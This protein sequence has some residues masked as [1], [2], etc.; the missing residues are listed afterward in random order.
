[1]QTE[2]S[3]VA[4]NLEDIIKYVCEKTSLTIEEIT[5]KTKLKKIVTARKAIIVLSD[6]YNEITNRDLSKILNISSSVISR[7]KGEK[8]DTDIELIG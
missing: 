8:I 6:K 1:M 3:R 7:I 5:R 2:V 4:I